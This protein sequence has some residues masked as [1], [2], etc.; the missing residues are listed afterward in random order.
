VRGKTERQRREQQ[1]NQAGRGRRA[2]G[3]CDV[4]LRYGGQRDG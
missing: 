2:Y 4:A 3:A 1:T